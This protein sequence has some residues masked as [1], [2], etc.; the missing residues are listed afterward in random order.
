MGG[1][2]ESTQRIDLNLLIN[3]VISVWVFGKIES[4]KEL[5]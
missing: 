5:T 2:I 4:T 3:S 1:G